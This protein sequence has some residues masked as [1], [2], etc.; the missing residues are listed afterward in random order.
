MSKR[1]WRW[2]WK[3]GGDDTCL[4]VDPMGEGGNSEVV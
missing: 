1:N 2:N 4:A 3:V